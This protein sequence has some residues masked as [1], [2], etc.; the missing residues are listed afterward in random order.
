MNLAQVI[1]IYNNSKSKALYKRC[2]YG[3]SDNVTDCGFS[4][5][6]AINNNVISVIKHYPGHGIT[7]KDSHF[8]VR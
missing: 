3:D 8:I 5:L 7:R 2:F 4:Y 6:K 1:D